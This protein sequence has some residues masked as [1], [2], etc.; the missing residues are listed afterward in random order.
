MADLHRDLSLTIAH[1]V[2]QGVV[3]LSAGCEIKLSVERHPSRKS[4][5]GNCWVRYPAGDLS[6]SL[7]RSIAV[8]GGLASLAFERGAPEEIEP[9]EA[10]DKL[11][12]GELGLSA[13]DAQMAEGFTMADVAF[14]ID[15]LCDRW[16]I[17]T[18][19]VERMSP[20]ILN[21]TSRT[22]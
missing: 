1:V 19:E 4:F 16:R 2:G 9:V 12:S 11:Q 13:S 5:G 6:D 8:A 17:I 14:V 7:R 15:V 21:N 20:V 22:H 3:A 10:F 18:D